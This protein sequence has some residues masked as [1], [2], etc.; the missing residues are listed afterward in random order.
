MSIRVTAIVVSHEADAYL[1]KTISGIS[2]QT[3]QPDRVILVDSSADNVS[4]GDLPETWGRVSVDPKT[5]F[6][7]SVQ[8]AIEALGEL[9]NEWIWLL[10]DDSSPEPSALEELVRKVEK[11]PSVAAVGP[12]QLSWSS[13]K[14][15]A[16]LGL[17]MSSR[18]QVI[19]P[20]SGELD[21]SQHDHVEDVLATGTAGLLV[22]RLNYLEVG[23]LQENSPPLAADVELGIKLRRLG[24]R[25]VVAPQARIQHAS[26]SLSGQ[27]PRRFL[28]GS[29]ESAIRKAQWHLFFT[30]RS[31]FLVFAAWLFAFPI[32]FAR[33]IWHLVSKQPRLI[34]PE[35]AAAIWAFFTIGRRLS[36]RARQPRQ[37]SFSQLKP[38]LASREQIRAQRFAHRDA[39]E[40]QINLEQLSLAGQQDAVK[41]FTSAGAWL[42]MLLVTLTNWSLFPS[43]VAAT[44]SSV[45]PLAANWFQLFDSAGASF[46][47][48]GFGLWAPADPFNWVLLGIGSITFWQPSIALAALIFLAPGLAFATAWHF[49]AIVTPKAWVRNSSA[50]AYALSPAVT[51]ALS[52]ARVTALV[53][54]VLLPALLLHLHKVLFRKDSASSSKMWASVATAGLILA[55]IAA[56]NPALGLLIGISATLVGLVKIRRL[57]YLLWVLVPTAVIFGP[58]TLY[59]LL[60]GQPLFLLA[61]PSV[62]PESHNFENWQLLLGQ[63]PIQSSLWLQFLFVPTL[64]FA[65]LGLLHRR[66]IG[67][68]MIT[69]AAVALLVSVQWLRFPALGIDA[70]ALADRILQN[71]PL[72]ALLLFSVGAATLMALAL[73]QLKSPWLV[74]MALLLVAPLSVV[75]WLK[76]VEFSYATDQV[77]P[78]IVLAEHQSGSPLKTLV[79]SPETVA[80]QTRYAV[81][82]VDG[83]G[84]QLEEISSVYRLSLTLANQGMSEADARWQQIAAEKEL[85]S[86]LVA[87]LVSA[88]NSDLG[89]ILRSANIGYVLV[90]K[91]NS[92]LVRELGVNLDAIK[93]LESIGETE[94]GSLWRVIDPNQNLDLTASSESRW[95]LTKAAQVGVLGAYLLLAIPTRGARRRAA[96]DS[97]LFNQEGD[98]S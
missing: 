11:S 8:T 48:L 6:P 81:A 23:G 80:G 78:S 83:D 30:Q 75:A 85:H 54:A 40:S 97:A 68:A 89:E 84:V 60:L 9:E 95:S 34:A 87:N 7:K 26:L 16:Q 93:E 25:V 94:Y 69:I 55:L 45:R 77:A 47:D 74:A 1:A 35:L 65:L 76:P 12:K 79:V 59:Y 50:F 28:G 71:S 5:T 39:L 98:E 14:R 32:A 43:A 18:G 10:H 41:S 73:G 56:A 96:K 42:I 37:I 17:T 51:W 22:N 62:V 58:T 33:T 2:L 13:P 15:L 70:Q 88:N 92:E 4:V 52:E 20:H 31:L 27:R 66:S 64:I 91:S 3:L 63:T 49:V 67:S 90:P 38:L 29:V 36:A 44:G 46:Q 72:P 82:L 53:I 61:D 24:K 19:A 86:D 57:G 21:Q